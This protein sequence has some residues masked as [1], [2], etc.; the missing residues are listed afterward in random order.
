MHEKGAL[1]RLY[2]KLE[3]SSGL[4]CENDR[5]SPDGQLS[6][7]VVVTTFAMDMTMSHFFFAGVTNAYDLVLEVQALTSQRVVAVDSHVVAV[8]IADG[9]DLHAA[10]RA[11]SMDSIADS[12]T[13]LTAPRPNRILSVPSCASGSAAPGSPVT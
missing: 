8:D 9:N 13:F 2:R 5:K 4:T 1:R 3:L 6:L 12:P 10:V 7:S 11:R